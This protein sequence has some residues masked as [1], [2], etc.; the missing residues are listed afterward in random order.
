MK[1][2]EDTK[3]RIVAA[4]AGL[5][6]ERG[7]HGTGI[8]QILARAG[9]PRGSLYFHF[10]GGKDE[11]V[12]AAIAAASFEVRVHLE[13]TLHDV[14]TPVAAVAGLVGLFRSILVDSDFRKGCPV[15][16][17]ALELSGT[18]SPVNEAC[19]QAY[20]E[21]RHVV[22][23]FLGKCLATERAKDLADVLFCLVEGALLVARTT[24]DLRPL[25]VAE[26]HGSGIV[27]QALALREKQT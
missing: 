13:T 1:K 2:G 12:V 11:I 22:A 10:P 7:Y 27:E 24:R 19:A 18:D 23:D 8:N 5:L 26:R 14:Q 9:A 4:T 20:R 3:M 6:D 25:D 16:T 17:V 21:W 15:S